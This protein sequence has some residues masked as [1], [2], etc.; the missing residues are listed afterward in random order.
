MAGCVTEFLA[1]YVPGRC[2]LWRRKYGGEAPHGRWWT[3]QHSIAHLNGAIAER[4]AE[5][6]IDASA[7]ALIARLIRLLQA[8]PGR[9]GS[10]AS[11]PT[12]TK[13][14]G[15]GTSPAPRVSAIP[16][17]YA[18]AASA[19]TKDGAFGVPQPVVAS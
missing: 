8:I 9:T 3:Q 5:H 16:R 18:W 11:T 14:A 7:N 4:A 6:G 15:D 19:A 2:R 10:T 1:G 13:G 17:G 12:R